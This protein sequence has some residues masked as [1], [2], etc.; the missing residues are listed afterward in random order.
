MPQNIWICVQ[1]NLKICIHKN[2]A[3]CNSISFF[4]PQYKQTGAA[5]CSFLTLG[6]TFW[7]TVHVAVTTW[8]ENGPNPHAAD[9]EGI[10][11]IWCL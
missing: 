2:L 4:R 1:N 6:Q 8:R 10:C 7:D 11:G 9:S 3:N 5:N